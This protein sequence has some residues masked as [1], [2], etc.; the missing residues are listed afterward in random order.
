M[1]NKV[2]IWRFLEIF[3]P[4]SVTQVVIFMILLSNFKRTVLHD[5]LELEAEISTAKQSDIIFSLFVFGWTLHPLDR[6]VYRRIA[7][8]PTQYSNDGLVGLYE[9]P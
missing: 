8:P 5:Y 4:E 7:V 1:K 9:L 2:E 6:H 3:L